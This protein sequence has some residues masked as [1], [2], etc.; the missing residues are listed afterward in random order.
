MLFAKKLCVLQI[1]QSLRCDQAHEVLYSKIN[2]KK[3]F[4]GL[5]GPDRRPHDRQLVSFE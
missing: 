1:L 5:E 4:T 3:L 2:H